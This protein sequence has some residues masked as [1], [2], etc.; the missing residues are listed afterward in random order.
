MCANVAVVTFVSWAQSR[1]PLS[2]H[3][4]PPVHPPLSLLRGGASKRPL[5]QSVVEI[6]IRK[7]TNNHRQFSTYRF[8]LLSV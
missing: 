2:V 1:S 5:H 3:L 6:A 8:I 4:V 7:L